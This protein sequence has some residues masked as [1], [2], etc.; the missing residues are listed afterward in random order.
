M[1]LAELMQRFIEDLPKAK[2]SKTVTKRAAHARLIMH[3]L[4]A[5]TPIKSLKR[6][7][8]RLFLRTVKALPANWAQSSSKAYAQKPIS[9][10]TA[11]AYLGSFVAAMQFAEDEGLISKSPA[12]GLRI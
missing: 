6:E 9:A 7:D 10:A 11:N 2:S 3:V 1:S 5:K 8:A 4:G 12:R